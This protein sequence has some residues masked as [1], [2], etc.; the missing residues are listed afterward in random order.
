MS[1][2]PYYIILR[3]EEVFMAAGCVDDEDVKNK[4]VDALIKDGVDSNDIY[5]KPFWMIFDDDSAHYQIYIRKGVYTLHHSSV[6]N[7]A[8][9]RGC[10]N[11]QKGEGNSE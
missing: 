8:A 2:V 11:Y 7:E 5:V 4:A 1:L 3:G 6:I 10:L 9:G